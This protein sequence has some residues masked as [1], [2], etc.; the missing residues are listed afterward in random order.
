MKPISP[1]A[2]GASC[3]KQ[4][5]HKTMSG[6]LAVGIIALGLGAHAAHAQSQAAQA[7]SNDSGLIAPGAQVVKV[8]GEFGFIEGP[9]ADKDGNL[10]FTDINNNRIHKLDLNGALSIVR[11]PTNRANGLIFD[12]DGNLIA[13]EGGGKRVTSMAPDGTLTVLAHEYNGKPLNAPNDVWIDNKGGMYFTDP[14]Y[15]GAD[16]L[17]QDGEHVYYLSADRKTLTRVVSDMGKPNGI[18]GTPDNRRLYIAD[19]GLRKIF[20]FAINPDGS[21]GPKQ[22]FVDSG[23][24]GM[25]LDEQGNLYITWIGGVGIYD[26]TGKQL[27][28]IRVPEM[29]AN[30]GFAGKNHDILYI[31]ARTGL[32]SIQMAVKGQR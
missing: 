6:L 21:L 23:S 26:S 15:S 29:P 30:V 13:C 24:D 22:E 14:N 31:P 1:L 19:T 4:V 2:V 28:L 5:G 12:K 3:P 10:F 17:T 32:Y 11:E 16:N 27:E 18:I 7:Q 9:A 20:V 25:T 8:R